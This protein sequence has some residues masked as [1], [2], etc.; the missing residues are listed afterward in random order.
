[1]MKGACGNKLLAINLLV[2]MTASGVANFTNT[3]LI[4][5]AEA[6]RGIK[7]YSDPEYKNEVG[8]SKKC[9]LLAVEYTSISRAALAAFC[10]AIPIGMMMTINI[11]GLGPTRRLPKIAADVTTLS[12]GLY[13]GLPLSVALFPTSLFAKG[14]DIEPEFRHY[15]TVYFDRGK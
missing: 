9:A 14:C 4:R 11:A 12:I 3:M 5:H 1:M 8:L 7:V 10:M 13:L 15:E 2:N 6:E